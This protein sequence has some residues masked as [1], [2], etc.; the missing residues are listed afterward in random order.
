LCGAANGCQL[1]SS[2]P[3]KG[4]CWCYSIEIPAALIERVPEELRNR[5]CICRRCV[6]EFHRQ[7]QLPSAEAP[8]VRAFTLIEL[9]VVIA[10]IAV[11]AGMLLPA[12]SRAKSSARRVQCVNHLRQL[13]LAS[14]MYWDD[15]DG[16]AFRWRGASTN[17]GR[18]YWFG[19]IEDGSEGARRFDATHG[20][21][22]P[23]LNGRGVEV[24]P[25][26]H[27]TAPRMK[28]K[29]TGASYGYGY[30]LSLSA[31]EK[32]PAVNTARIA[33]PSSLALLA[34]AA[35][36]NTFQPPAS[37]EHPMIEEFY[38]LSTNEPTVHF[39]HQG[40]ANAVFCD[41][42]VDPSKPEKDSLDDRLP[43]EVIGRLPTN[44]LLLQ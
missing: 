39:R 10:I 1:C 33:S 28:L 6:E 7:K 15:N 34:D 38:Y 31:P 16:R 26:F 43:G 5:A 4:P 14:Q 36:V 35:Q 25:E 12:L 3:Y 17:G 27:Y 19:W 8:H 9:L 40:R 23:Y 24:C 13:G 20:S 32:Q 2:T 29:A 37:P 18:V 41:G 30:N 21:L 44:L 42:H 11:L 22:F